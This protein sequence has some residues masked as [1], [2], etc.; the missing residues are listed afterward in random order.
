LICQHPLE[1]AIGENRDAIAFAHAQGM[2]PGGD[3]ARAIQH[4]FSRD[5]DPRV[6][7]FIIQGVRLRMLAGNLLVHLNQRRRLTEIERAPRGF[8][9]Q[10]VNLRLID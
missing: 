3:V 8:V 7:L 1:P 9:A 10:I 2:Q 5:R 6:A 4:L